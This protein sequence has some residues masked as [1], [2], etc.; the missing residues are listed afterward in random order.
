MKYCVFLPQYK[1]FYN[2]NPQAIVWTFKVIL[3]LNKSIYTHN[4][5]FIK[6]HL[7]HKNIL[8]NDKLQYDLELI[9]SKHWDKTEY[10]FA[11]ISNSS[12]L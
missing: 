2:T 10:S 8:I 12:R 3:P 6:F 1:G 7:N 11:N 5:V 9:S 4:L